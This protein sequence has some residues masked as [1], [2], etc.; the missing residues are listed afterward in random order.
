MGNLFTE[1]Q[2]CSIVQCDACTEVL[3]RLRRGHGLNADDDLGLGLGFRSSGPSGGAGNGPGSPPWAE[4]FSAQDYQPTNLSEAELIQQAVQRSRLEAGLLAGPAEP[5]ATNGQRQRLVDD[6][7]LAGMQGI[8]SPGLL[9]S[10]RGAVPASAQRPSEDELMAQALQ[11]SE[12][13]EECRQRTQLREEQNNEYEESLRI[14]REREEERRRKQQEEEQKQK[15][16]EEAE[17]RKKKEEADA[18]AKAKE[19]EAAKQKRISCLM[20][21]ARS[22]LGDEPSQ[23]ELG[24]I[25]VRIRTPEGKALKRAF[26][27]TD[28]I[29]KVYDFVVAE[30][31]EQ[32]AL[33][34]FRLFS[35]MPK[36]IYDDREKALGDAGLQG[37][38]AL[39]V[40][41]IES[42]DEA[43]AE[44]TVGCSE[45]VVEPANGQ[46]DVVMTTAPCEA[47]TAAKTLRTD[48]Q[49]GGP[50]EAQEASLRGGRSAGSSARRGRSMDPSA[51]RG[52]STDPSA[53]R[54]L[55][56]DPSAG[57][58]RSAD[59]R[60]EAGPDEA[61]PD[62]APCEAQ[63]ETALVEA[64]AASPR[65]PRAE[66]GPGEAHAVSG[67]GETQTEAA[68]C[69]A[70]AE[71]APS[72]DQAETAPVEDP[73]ANGPSK[74]VM[75]SMPAGVRELQEA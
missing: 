42:D 20:D 1:C 59:P 7:D 47:E 27:G 64:Q 53:R 17:K 13:E 54:A 41:I 57:R 56:V 50:N 61:H 12:Q 34:N 6:A 32:L 36:T 25:V 15:D 40:E 22:R 10:L 3:P 52:R 44:T 55:S 9:S 33:Q 16:F 66:S 63:A 58:G 24:R 35:N 67:P 45:A 39:L 71:A 74:A 5:P 60:A 2:T 37:Q 72:E 14:D 18:I 23:K 8:Y 19:E 65:G 31:G 51:G 62:A 73:L 4:G 43:E 29:G 30:G 49:L 69:E 28:A 75:K 11:A 38:C 26:R 48:T 70:R 46:C 21:E 68:P